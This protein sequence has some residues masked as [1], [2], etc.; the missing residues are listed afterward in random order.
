MF[1]LFLALDCGN[2]AVRDDTKFVVGA[3]HDDEVKIGPWL[4]FSFLN[5]LEPRV[6]RVWL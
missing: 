6:F 5:Q 3:K 1:L 4:R 2:N